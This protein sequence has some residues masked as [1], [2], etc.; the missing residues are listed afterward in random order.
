MSRKIKIIILSIVLVIISIFIIN[1]F[2]IN[3]IVMDWQTTTIEEEL[4]KEDYDMAQKILK[5]KAMKGNTSEIALME[6]NQS[7]SFKRAI[8]E[9][10][11]IHKLLSSKTE[12]QETNSIEEG[13]PQ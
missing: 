8:D 1:V 11:M 4:T 7:E 6:A 12:K 3:S 2:I 13:I 10:E 9:L 5:E